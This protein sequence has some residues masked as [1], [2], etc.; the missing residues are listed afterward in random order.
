MNEQ[1]KEA[2]SVLKAVA[3]VISVPLTYRKA[4]KVLNALDLWCGDA[5]TDE[6]VDFINGTI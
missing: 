1:R 3:G 6:W 2:L 5:L 4:D